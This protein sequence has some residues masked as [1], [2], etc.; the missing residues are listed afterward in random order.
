MTISTVLG[1]GV[2]PVGEGLCDVLELQ[3]PNA[4]LPDVLISTILCHLTV[5]ITY[6]PIECLAVSIT[7]MEA[8][9]PS[10]ITVQAKDFKIPYDMIFR[11]ELYNLANV[12]TPNNTSPMSSIETR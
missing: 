7:R 11:P 12:K 1:C 9:G 10:I 3:A 5:N 8:V 2:M 4:L 6:E